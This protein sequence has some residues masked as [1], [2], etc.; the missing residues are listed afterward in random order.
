M[1]CVLI[2]FYNK[3]IIEEKSLVHSPQHLK[4]CNLVTTN[5]GS[6]S[7]IHSSIHLNLVL[8]K[9]SQINAILFSIYF[10]VICASGKKHLMTSKKRNSVG[11]FVIHWHGLW[12][13][14]FL[15]C[16]LSVRRINSWYFRRFV[17][18]SLQVNISPSNLDSL[19]KGRQAEE[20]GGRD[21][22]HGL[23]ICFMCIFR[24][25]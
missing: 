15:Q 24:L 6:L 13:V 25:F 22:A 18:S 10:F 23:F 14:I 19:C 2:C 1:V 8:Q 5:Q 17:N 11:V 7:S 3:R 12:K 9:Q 16:Q 20:G 4:H 21:V